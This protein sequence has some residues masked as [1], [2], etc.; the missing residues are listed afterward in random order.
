[1]RNEL[2]II[3]QLIEQQNNVN[4]SSSQRE[5]LINHFRD[6]GYS[7]ATANNII[8]HIEPKSSLAESWQQAQTLISERLPQC[9]EDLLNHGGIAALVGPTGVGKTTTIAKLAAHF[10][11]RHGH[12]QIG[13]ITIDNYRIAAHEQISTYGTILDVPVKIA[14]DA[15][16]LTI[17]LHEFKDK[18]LILID[19]AGFNH[20]DEKIIDNMSMLRRGINRKL[21]KYLVLS[22]TTRTTQ[23]KNIVNIYKTYNIN[24]LIITKLDEARVT[25]GALSVAMEHN[26]PISFI[27]DGQRV[28]EDLRLA[29]CDFLL[30]YQQDIAPQTSTPVIKT[31][32]KT[33]INPS[34]TS[35]K[36]EKTLAEQ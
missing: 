10:V 3:R 24:S 12:D 27:T 6:H 23:L 20:N 2:H 17:I 4:T 5:L 32:K 22:A 26:L 21:L 14:T 7:Y 19:T 18:K 25:G 29:S 15:Q 30:N 16:D 34:V 33:I 9:Q 13:I 28:P 11:K 36:T 31:V 1:M 35:T 8:N